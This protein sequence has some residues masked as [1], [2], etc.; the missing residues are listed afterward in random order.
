[1]SETHEKKPSAAG[2]KTK[3]IFY[4]I[5]IKSLLRP[6]VTNYTNRKKI[7]IKSGGL[8]GVK[9]KSTFPILDVYVLSDRTLSQ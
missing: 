1:M 7:T 8:W 9:P 6:P 5:N 4:L 2:E 3:V